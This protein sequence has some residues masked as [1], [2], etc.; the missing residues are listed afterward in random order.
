MVSSS[1]LSNSVGAGLEV[2]AVLVALGPVDDVD[3]EVGEADVDLVELV[4]EADHLLGQHLVDLVVEQIALL[5]AELDE[6]LDRGVLL[7]DGCRGS[8]WSKWSLLVELDAM[9][10]DAGS[11]RRSPRARP[12]SPCKRGSSALLFQEAV[13]RALV[14]WRSRL[15]DLSLSSLRRCSRQR[16]LQLV[17]GLSQ[18]PVLP[19]AKL[20]F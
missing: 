14:P 7:F 5:L 13:R 20:A 18:S 10:A 12:G 11:D 1:F 4:G 2:V 3:A 17:E 8:K 6:L 19:G 9:T 16:S 15:A